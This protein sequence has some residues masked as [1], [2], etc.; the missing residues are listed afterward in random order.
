MTT[1][2]VRVAPFPDGE[3]E[4][5]GHLSISHSLYM[6]DVWDLR[7]LT[8]EHDEEHAPEY[9]HLLTHPHTHSAPA[10]EEEWSWD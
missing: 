10:P 1:P 3:F 9:A 4:L 5:H 6:G 8:Q 2:G 7:A